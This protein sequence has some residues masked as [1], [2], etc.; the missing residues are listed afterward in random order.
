MI[1]A[2]RLTK[3]YARD[4][5]ALDEVS[6]T[7]QPGE[8]VAVLGPSGAGKTTLFRCL[9]GLTAVDGGSVV[10]DGRD[11]V[12]MSRRELRTARQSIA[13]IFQQFNL[14]RR[15]AWLGCRPGACCCAASRA[16]TASSRSAVSTPSGLRTEPTRA[17]I[18]SREGSSSAWPS[19]ARWRKRR[20]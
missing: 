12:A 9:T 11:I 8:F 17:P 16:P 7:A 20:R 1:S 15:L 2:E 6:F 3:T 19:P 13:L 10:L 5:I 14:I 18:S 4:I